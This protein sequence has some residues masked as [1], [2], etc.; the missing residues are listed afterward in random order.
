MGREDL[1]NRRFGRLVATKFIKR[2]SGG[3]SI[4]ECVCDCGNVIQT[5]AGYLK[6]GHTTSCG[7]YCKERTKEALTKHGKTG[8]RL[9]NIWFCIKSR[10]YN[11]NNDAYHNYGGRGIK[12][13]DEWKDNFSA[14]YDWAIS[15]G[16]RE[17]LSIDRIN[18]DGDYTPD[19][20]RWATDKEQCSNTRRTH[21]ITFDGKTMCLHDWESYLGFSRG[22]ISARINK[23][24]WTIEKALTT[25]THCKN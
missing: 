10:C 7:C 15:N 6:S 21:F 11:D 19:N 23:L 3:Q 13:C 12:M 2:S 18:V 17:N 20:C 9:H 25:P 24:N 5:S 1:S 4:W 14:F 8:S 16:Y 22:T